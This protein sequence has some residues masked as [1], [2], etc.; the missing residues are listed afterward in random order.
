MSV[1]PKTLMKRRMPELRPRDDENYNLS[2][3]VSAAC[4]RWLAAKKVPNDFTWLNL[5]RAE[6]RGEVVQYGRKP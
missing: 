6:E 4:D 5:R 2:A 3:L 1:H